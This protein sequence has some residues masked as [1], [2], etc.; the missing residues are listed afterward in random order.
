[1]PARPAAVSPG[2]GAEAAL[3]RLLQLGRLRLEGSVRWAE[4][5]LLVELSGA[6]QDRLLADEA[7]VLEAIEY[8]LPRMIRQGGAEPPRC[9]VDSGGYRAGREEGLRQLALSTAE[10][11]RTSG[12]AV[13]LEAMG[14]A[15]RRVVHVTLAGQPGVATESEGDGWFKRVRVAPAPRG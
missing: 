13:L 14:P 6:D 5:E 12:Q 10:K 4:G 15:E 3:S 9:R 1:E 7:E 11:V 2:E 8:L